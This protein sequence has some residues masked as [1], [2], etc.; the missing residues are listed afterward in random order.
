MTHYIKFIGIIILAA[1]LSSCTEFLEKK[2]DKQLAV[3]YTLQDFQALMDDGS[4]IGTKTATEGEMSADDYYLSENDLGQ[5]LDSDRGIYNWAY[6]VAHDDR[7]FTGWQ[8]AYREIYYCNLVIE[9]ITDMTE[10][11]KTSARGK[12]ILGQAFLNR[13][14]AM[15]HVAEIWTIGYD[16]GQL[17]SPYGLPLRRSTNF[18]EKS[19]RSTVGETYTLI[20]EDLLRAKKLLPVEVISKY[21]PSRAAGYGFLARFNLFINKYNKAK[22][23][24]DSAIMLHG[25]GLLD[26]A[27]LDKEARYTMPIP[28]NNPE[29]IFYRS[30]AS[31]PV[32]DQSRAKMAKDLLD[33]YEPN[34]TRRELFFLENPDG[35]ERFRAGYRGSSAMFSG[36]ALDEMYLIKMEGLI[37]EGKE[38][39]ALGLLKEYLPTK[40][41][42][43]FDE[44]QM[45]GDL[46]DFVLKERRRQLTMRGIRWSDIKRLNREGHG[47][48]LQR[49][50]GATT[51]VLPSNDLRFAL[52]VPQQVL[53]LT[54]IQPNPR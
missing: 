42:V 11:E 38:E 10:K 37:R 36:I 47:I 50:E 15:L 21:R 24:A 51:D 40:Y 6:Y 49:K 25:G 35:S 2:S 44:L 23:Y 7:S 41:G 30:L 4:Y 8:H 28:E 17:D 19:V 16:P 12:D 53:D 31:S 27:T 43:D 46:L 1:L 34:D 45:K 3:P 26:Y 9:G 22:I 18:N 39:E 20:E 32:L 14:A 33:L 52:P 54:G 13:A 5:M 29:V 48:S